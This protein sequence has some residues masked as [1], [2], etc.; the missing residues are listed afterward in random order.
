[1]EKMKE[2]SNLKNVRILLKI[3]PNLK[4]DCFITFSAYITCV[5]IVK[6]IYLMKVKRNFLW[7]CVKFIMEIFKK[8]GSDRM[9][10]NV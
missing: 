2:T 10:Y 4:N 5:I 8:K 7:Y 9:I 3:L 1:M 6:K